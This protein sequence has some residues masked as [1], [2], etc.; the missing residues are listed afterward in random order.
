MMILERA[1]ASGQFLVMDNDLTRCLGQGDLTVVRAD[2]RWTAP[3]CLECFSDEPDEPL[4]E[5]LEVSVN[6]AG[7]VADHPDHTGLFS[8]FAEALGLKVGSTRTFQR[9]QKERQEKE[10]TGS[11]RVALRLATRRIPA[12]QTESSLWGSA[13]TVIRGALAEGTAYHTPEPGITF[14]AVRNRDGDE[15]LAA[16]EQLFVRLRADGVPDGAPSVS[17]HDFASEDHMSAVAPPVALWKLTRDERT[18]VLGGGVFFACIVTANAWANAFSR[19]GLRLEDVKG[20]WIIHGDANA[21]RFSRLEVRKLQ[22]GVAFGGV[23]PAAVA[24]AVRQA[25]G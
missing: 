16:L 13:S 1:H 17:A 2:G 12:L 9:P 25:I 19:V 4:R 10:M 8:E 21:V 22:Y 18:A 23:S 20:H 5:G 24:Q 14:L 15:S 3:L 6:L 11:A 7:A